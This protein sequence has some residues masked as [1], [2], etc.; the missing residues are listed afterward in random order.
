MLVLYIA[1]EHTFDLHFDYAS[2][3][4]QNPSNPIYYSH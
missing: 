3:E 1:Y 2:P 4:V